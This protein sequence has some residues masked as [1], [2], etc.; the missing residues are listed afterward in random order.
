MFSFN[1]HKHFHTGE[2]G[3]CTTDDD[4]LATRLRMIRNHGENVAQE[5]ADGDLTNIVGFNLRLTELQSAVGL[6]QLGKMEKLV[7]DRVAVADR[8][9]RE[10][11]QAARHQCRRR[12][13][14][15]AATSIT[16]GW[17]ASTRRSPACPR[18]VFARAVAAEGVPISTGYVEPLYLLPLFRK[19]IAIGREGF[20]FT[21]SNR[22]YGKGLCPVAERMHEREFLELDVCSWAFTDSEIGAVVDAFAKV[23]ARR[24]EL[25]RPHLRS[26]AS[27]T[28][29]ERW[30]RFVASRIELFCR[31]R[32]DDALDRQIALL[33]PVR[34][35]QRG[36]TVVADGMWRNPNHFFR[37]RL[38]VQA[39]AK[40]G[41]FH[42]LGVL[43][44]RE[45]WRERRAL[46]RIGFAEFVYLD[47][48]KELRADHFMAQAGELLAA[49]KS[50][51]DRL[52]LLLPEGLPA[53]TWFDTVLKLAAHPQ[54]CLD[55][56][57]WRKTLAEVL[58]NC[59]IYSRELGKREVAHV[60]LSHP[61]KNEWATLVWLALGR[62]IPAYHLTGFCEGIRIR[63]FRAREDY[64]NPV[65]HM[66]RAAFEA[67]PAAVREALCNLGARDLALRALR[68]DER[69]QCPIR[70]RPGTAHRR[71]ACRAGRRSAAR[72][73]G[74]SS[75]STDMSGT[76][77]PTPSRWPTSPTFS[78]G[79]APPS[80]E[81]ARSTT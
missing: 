14:R 1:Y 10:L 57:L 19:R 59:A 48:D 52:A 9:T 17:H 13:A 60:V 12:C 79:C 16:S 33:G 53:Y 43:R 40:R 78:T 56:P 29:P 58:R 26:L 69:H 75:S 22:S 38:F 72:P 47:D 61:W 64:A 76:T 49:A 25:R 62:R 35:P 42:L 21:L 7:A 55:H 20:P 45:D 66:S 30:R 6:A 28:D 2:G 32:G 8:L 54:P 77:F 15:A 51:A 50:H 46:E 27:L 73:R 74:R 44:R 68:Q 37:L 65:E 80:H 71:S 34:M 41:D 3:L 11:A 39:L 63:R 36:P 18:D 31:N 23:Y 4:R 5:L 24:G 67:L 70:L 81:S